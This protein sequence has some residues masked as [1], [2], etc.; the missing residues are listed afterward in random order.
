MPGAT[1]SIVINAPMEKVFA[2][3]TDYE[4][5][6][7]FIPE[8]RSVRVLERASGGAATVQ[9]DADVV[10]RIRYTLRHVA[11]PPS[12]V[13]WSFVEGEVLKDNHGSWVLEPAGEGKTKA[14]YT[15]EIGLGPLVPRA[16]INTLVDTSL[17]KLLE[18]FKRAAERV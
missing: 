14:T 8:V 10:K 18:N 17:P 1:R 12:R 11:H 9:Y 4:R 6:A 2:T 13:E 5:Y 3:I 7:D 15:V 16:I